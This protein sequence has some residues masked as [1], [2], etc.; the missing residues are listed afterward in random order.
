MEER[1]SPPTNE[2]VAA[3]QGICWQD[4]SYLRMYGLYAWNALEY[5]SHSP[6]YD[7]QSNNELLRMQV[8][9][10]S[11]CYYVALCV[12]RSPFIN[13]TSL[14]LCLPKGFGVRRPTGHG[15]L[16]EHGGFGVQVIIG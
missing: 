14:G 15:I 3:H 2:V 7:Q 5:F 1:S 16:N 13:A 11:S 4:T 8:G 9:S 6:F 10:N 12:M